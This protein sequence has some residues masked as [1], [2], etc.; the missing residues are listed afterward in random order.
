MHRD[1]PLKLVVTFCAITFASQALG[2]EIE[3]YLP[4][5]T[6]PCT[7][8]LEKRHQSDPPW[9][10]TTNSR[11][12]TPQQPTVYLHCIFNNDPKNVVEVNWFVPGIKQ[13]IPGNRSA[14]GP[15]YSSEL[16]V[17]YPEGCLVFGNLR[18][19]SLKAQFWA[20]PE[21]AEQLNDEKGKDCLALQRT[22][23]RKEEGKAV[24]FSDIVA[25]FRIFLHKDPTSPSS[26]LFAFEGITGVRATGPRS[27]QAYVTYRIRDAD[28]APLTDG[29]IPYLIVPDL[30]GEMESLQKLIVAGNKGDIVPLSASKEPTTV[31]F[32]VKGT[33]DWTLRE[34][35]YLV[36]DREK[37]RVVGNVFSPVYVPYPPK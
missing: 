30:R 7:G 26:A 18:D 29:A 25:P 35:E 3:K 17:G 6:G 31:G 21:D 1:L 32:E 12:P 27:Y 10:F 9:D 15:K 36:L 34:L 13:A 33:G 24:K 14:I 11:K 20:R 5:A 4:K 28:D 19:K 37:K 22:G 16:P 23:G 8:E 2:Q